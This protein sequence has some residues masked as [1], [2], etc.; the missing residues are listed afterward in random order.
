MA[1]LPPGIDA[2]RLAIILLCD[3]QRHRLDLLGLQNSSQPRLDHVGKWRLQA[4]VTRSS[5]LSAFS[6]TWHFC[7]AT[8]RTLR[9]PKH[10]QQMWMLSWL[11][12]WTSDWLNTGSPCA[13][14]AAPGGATAAAA[15]E[16]PG[17]GKQHSTQ[18]AS[19]VSRHHAR[20]CAAAGKCSPSCAAGQR[21][22]RQPAR[23]AG[24]EK[25]ATDN[26]RVWDLATL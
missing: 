1:A 14:A 3:A 26:F 2:L 13:R 15:A 10:S 4:E 17:G 16:L 7:P 18:A 6:S 8:N 5:T 9:P 12:K 11:G 21:S 23:P 24:G 25:R 20:P 19:G 22:S